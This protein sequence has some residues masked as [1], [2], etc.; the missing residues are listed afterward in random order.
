MKAN[1][2]ARK[3]NKEEPHKKDASDSK[4]DEKPKTS[5]EKQ[6]KRI[7]IEEDSD[8]EEGEDE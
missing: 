5:S 7:A 1:Q 3:A 4:K 6:F 8:E 2:A